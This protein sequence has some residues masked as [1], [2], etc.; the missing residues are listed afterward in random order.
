MSLAVMLLRPLNSA[1]A[2]CYRELR[3]AALREHP[4]AYVTDLREESVLPIEEI[5][6]RLDGSTAVTFGAFDD[7]QVLSG[8]G[9]LLWTNRL[10]QRFRATIVGMYVPHAFR[11]QG[12][13]TALL[14]ACVGRARSLA[15][16]EEVCLC[17]T[18]G[19]DDAR[20]AYIKFGFQPDY[21]EPRYFK[22]AGE[23]YDIEWLKLPLSSRHSL[24]D[25]SG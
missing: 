20:A 15:E 13:A 12:I 21:V 25:A 8:I 18:V 10:R 19:N 2:E 24:A 1:D 7:Q 6:Q 4:L 23:Y 17:I 3:L 5:R 16:V 9:T 22:H 14:R 11:R